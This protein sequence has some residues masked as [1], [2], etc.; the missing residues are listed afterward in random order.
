MQMRDFSPFSSRFS[1][2][3]HGGAAILVSNRISIY[4]I[5]SDGGDGPMKSGN[6]HRQGAKSGGGMEITER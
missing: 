2:T 4:L 3:R 6:L 1:L 5:K